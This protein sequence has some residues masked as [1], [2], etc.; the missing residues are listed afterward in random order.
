MGGPGAP[1][2]PQESVAGMRKVIDGLSFDHTGRFLAY[3]G[4]VL[5]W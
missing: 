1:L 3:D 5:P 2:S 4:S